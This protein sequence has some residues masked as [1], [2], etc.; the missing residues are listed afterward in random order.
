MPVS[1]ASVAGMTRGLSNR[2]TSNVL[3]WQGVADRVGRGSAE[4]MISS[5]P[6]A[7]PTHLAAA[8]EDP[9]TMAT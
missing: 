3:Y 8:V 4:T 7:G 9:S 5:G 2:R 6:A 1:R